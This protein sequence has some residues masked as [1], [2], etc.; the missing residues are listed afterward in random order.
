M[1]DY[2]K[3]CGL[4]TQALCLDVPE[5]ELAATHVAF[6]SLLGT[7]ENASSRLHHAEE[8]VRLGE[9]A[10]LGCTSLQGNETLFRDKVSVLV[11]AY[12][13]LGVVLED[14]GKPADE[15]FECARLLAE[16]HLPG[17][18]VGAACG[19]AAAGAVQSSNPEFRLRPDNT[20]VAR[21]VAVRRLQR[22]WRRGRVHRAGAEARGVA[23]EPEM[24]P[25]HGDSMRLPPL[26]RRTLGAT[27]PRVTDGASPPPRA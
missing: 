22:A 18:D 17:S 20:P 27:L 25:A 10:I 23:A 13:N 8:A 9:A 14:A 2:G 3:P 15:P 1:S 26:P 6:C 5:E 21:S 7:I 12:H 24:R 19:G 11:V 16:Q 4:A